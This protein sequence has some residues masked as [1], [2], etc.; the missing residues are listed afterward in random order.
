MIKNISKLWIMH[1][2]SYEKEHLKVK[3]IEHSEVYDFIQEYS[4]ERK[5]DLKL[6]SAYD[7]SYESGSCSFEIKYTIIAEPT[8]LQKTFMCSNCLTLRHYYS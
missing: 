6:N 4:I 3:I 8:V 7:Y 5:E 1:T 2:Y